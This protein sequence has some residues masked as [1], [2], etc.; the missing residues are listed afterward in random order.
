MRKACHFF[1]SIPKRSACPRLE[2]QAFHRDGERES[3]G[4]ELATMHESRALLKMGSA[5]FAVP[6]WGL[7]S[8]RGGRPRWMIPLER[9]CEEKIERWSSWM[10]LTLHEANALS[11]TMQSRP[12]AG[13]RYP[14]LAISRSCMERGRCSEQGIGIRVLDL[15][16]GLRLCGPPLEGQG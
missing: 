8:A 7:P 4:K 10:M 14:R 5:L 2:T 3:A 1:L 13:W 16:V 6:F 15:E 11:K 9:E 12:R